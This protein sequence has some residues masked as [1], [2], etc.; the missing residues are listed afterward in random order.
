M[1]TSIA[2]IMDNFEFLDD[3]EDRYRYVI[4]L[5]KELEEI[6]AE[7]RTTTNKV[8]GCVS[9]V[10]LITHSET[11][12]NGEIRLYF[13]GDSDAHIVRGLIGI[14]IALFNGKTPTEILKTNLESIFEKIGL[15]EHLTRQRSDGLTSMIKRVYDDATRES[16]INFA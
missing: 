4:E 1:K 8:Q 12:R 15:R 10:W 2:E 7:E 11:D 5:G 9:Q 16:S 3:W 14:I 13:K 6:S